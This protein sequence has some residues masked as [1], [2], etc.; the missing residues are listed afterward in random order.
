MS[1]TPK[2]TRGP[3]RISR[4]SQTTVEAGDRGIC[5]TGG[6]QQNFD[7]ERIYAEN[8]ANGRLIAA[9]PDMFEALKAVNKLIAEA[10]MTGFN[11][12][13]GDWA[14]RLYDSQQAT[15]A[16]LSRVS[17]EAVDG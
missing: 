1:A 6:Y 17:G 10:A 15:S 2:F 7:S 16:A 11:C 5:S 12:H 14:Q 13:D 3:W 8:I 9:A 4:I